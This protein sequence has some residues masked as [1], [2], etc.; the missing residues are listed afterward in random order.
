MNSLI[1]YIE[2]L[3]VNRIAAIR[4]KDPD[5]EQEVKDSILLARDMSSEKMKSRRSLF[6]VYVGYM[7]QFEGR[8]ILRLC[9]S[10]KE[11]VLMGFY[12]NNGRLRAYTAKQMESIYSNP[13]APQ[14]AKQ[15]VTFRT[16]DWS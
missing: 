10:E 16:P 5:S 9:Y 1:K 12:A 14:E 3:D 15:N 13:N 4:V 11:Y 8:L 2:G 6:L 7:V